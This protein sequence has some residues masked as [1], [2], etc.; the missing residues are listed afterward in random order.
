MFWISHISK[1]FFAVRLV[2]QYVL[3]LVNYISCWHDSFQL[4]SYTWC[5]HLCFSILVLRYHK[6]F[7]KFIYCCICVTD[8]GFIIHWICIASECTLVHYSQC[9]Q[10][11]S[12]YCGCHTQKTVTKL[13]FVSLPPQR[14]FAKIFYRILVT[15]V[16]KVLRIIKIEKSLCCSICNICHVLSISLKFWF[17]SLFESTIDFRIIYTPSKWFLAKFQL[18]K[19]M[20]KQLHQSLIP[21]TTLYDIR[22]LMGSM[23]DL[24]PG[25]VN[26]AESLGFLQII[27]N[28]KKI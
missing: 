1:I 12:D 11:V 9:H 10:F 4:C 21:D 13:R 8:V 20:R 5:L 27:S 25:F 23:H 6:E 17:W 22:S 28:W 26:V 24:D 7:F 18:L 15:V 19:K 16:I 3:D 2:H 14:S